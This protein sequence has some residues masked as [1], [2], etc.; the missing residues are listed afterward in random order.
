MEKYP[1][2]S[3][4]G[5][6]ALMQDPNLI[7]LDASVKDN[8]SNLESEV[9]HLQI[10]NARFFD[11]K[12]DF[13]D[14]EAPFPNTL[15]S[16]TAFEKACQDLGIN[17]DSKL[18]VY[19]DLGIY[20]SPRVWWMFKVMG[21]AKVAVLD[22]GLPDWVTLGFP[23]VEKQTS[24]II[25]PQGNFEA[26]Y[27]ASLEASL[28]TVVG[29]LEKKEALV[30]DARPANRFQG[31]VEEPRKGV[32]S[33]HIPGSINIPFAALQSNGKFKDIQELKAVFA[34]KGVGQEPLI[35][36][37][38]SGLTACIVLL[39]AELAQVGGQKAIYDGSWAEW[40]SLSHLPIET[41]E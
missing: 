27:Q 3:A 31:K 5:L 15:P 8:V 34:S 20:S 1:I 24:P 2:I 16:P 21:H 14:P 26:N 17:K 10:P 19:D 40:G 9:S 18:V 32:R 39:A 36:S 12:K 35:F 23:T 29:N 11:L 30:I 38:G 28:T 37:C 41:G 25:Y 7:V 13:S 6:R 22:G 33:G 4:I